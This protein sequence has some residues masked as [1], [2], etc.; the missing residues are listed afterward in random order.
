MA[1]DVA[2]AA[3]APALYLTKITVPLFCKI[4]FND[5]SVINNTATVKT[6]YGVKECNYKTKMF[7]LFHPKKNQPKT[8]NIKE[9]IGHEQEQGKN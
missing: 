5:V 2:G 1:T 8:V 7:K 6:P 3:A 4:I 9:K